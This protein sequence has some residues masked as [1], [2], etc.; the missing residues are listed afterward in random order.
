MVKGKK[1]L[2]KEIVK[3]IKAEKVKMRPRAYFILGSVLLGIGVAGALLFSIIFTNRAFFRL[4]VFGPFG[5]LAFGKAGIGPFLSTFPFISLVLALIGIGGGFYLLRRYEFSYKR[6]L[7]SLLI[8]VAALVVTVGFVLD[9]VGFGERAKNY[10]S[11]APLYSY[12]AKGEDFVVGEIKAVEEGS[13]T[14]ITPIGDEVEVI[15]NENTRLPSGSDFEEGDR[16]R[17]VGEW[18]NDTF[19]AK[20]IGKGGLRWRTMET[21]GSMPGLKVRG[22]MDIRP[23]PRR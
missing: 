11:L 1:D 3:K 2:S 14:V 15:F 8:G 12:K 17:A 21:S 4:R 10:R 19:I 16:I 20:G 5:N 6:S 9:Q 13:L 7:I 18:E 23:G 22:K